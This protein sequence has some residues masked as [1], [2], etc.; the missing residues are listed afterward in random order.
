ML[1]A[2][3]AACAPEAGLNFVNDEQRA[4]L[5]TQSLRRGQEVGITHVTPPSAWMTSST[6]AAV[7]W[8]TAASNCSMLLNCMWL[9]SGS[10]GSNLR[11]YFGFQ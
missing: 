11:R 4:S 5:S 6:T 9:T 8:L 2:E 3:P 10:S 1:K 7:P